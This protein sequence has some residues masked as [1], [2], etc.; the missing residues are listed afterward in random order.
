MRLRVHGQRFFDSFSRLAHILTECARLHAR[1]LAEP[2]QR[3]EIAAEV[4]ALEAEAVR[5]RSAVVAD[6]DEVAIPPLDRTDV[7]Q[8]A[9][10]LH[11]MVE[12]LDGNARQVRAMGLGPAPEPVEQLGELLV[13]AARRVEVAVALLR[14]RERA[15]GGGAEM[16]RLEAE[17]D[18]ISDAAV[19][20]LFSG[21]PDPME[22]LRWKTLYDTLT[23]AI[24]RCRDVE[25][26]VRNV[27]R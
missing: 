9:S 25:S 11:G 19:E 8:L 26:M 12:L 6:M 1:L 27:V 21:S 17:G 3:E 18:A 15:E 14:E 2:G 16:E 4:A 10:R 24:H 20:A 7:H 13:R 23:D 22:A 5:L